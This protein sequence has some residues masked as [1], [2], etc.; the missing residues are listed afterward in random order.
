MTSPHLGRVVAIVRLPSPDAVV[1]AGHELAEAGLDSIEVTL[2]TPG[3]LD[4]VA[5]L[6][7]DLAGTCA[8]GAGSVRTPADVTAARDAGAQFLVTPTTRVEV[9]AEAAAA[10]LPVVCGAYTPTEIDVAWS[11]GA[12]MVKLFPASLAGPAY[13]R[14]L[15]APLPDVPVVPT[16]GVSPESVA[17]WAAAGAVAVGAGSALVNAAEV[18]AGDW[19]ALRRRARTFLDAAAAAAWPA[20]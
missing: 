13:L 19:P 3:A 1:R 12:T 20:G 15:L 18:A 2:T 7:A 17:Q 16:G 10:D 9:L 5:T 14:E 11:G 6:R 4:A 8:V